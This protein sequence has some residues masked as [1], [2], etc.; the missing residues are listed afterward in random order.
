M[1][2]FAN[3][4]GGVLFHPKYSVSPPPYAAGNQGSLWARAFG[5][6]VLPLTGRPDVLGVPGASGLFGWR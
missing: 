5:V 4:K 2:A 1:L 3:V 6:L